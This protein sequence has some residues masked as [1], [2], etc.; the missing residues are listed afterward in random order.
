MCCVG[1][2]EKC[3]CQQLLFGILTLK[4]STKGKNEIESESFFF[5]AL[6]PNNNKKKI[7]YLI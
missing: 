2:R 6:L 4:T 7:L 5:R 1:G 3:E